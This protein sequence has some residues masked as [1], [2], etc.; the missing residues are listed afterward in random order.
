[1][2]ML[3]SFFT[4]DYS[5]EEKPVYKSLI[6]KI[7][8]V[9]DSADFYREPVVYLYRVIGVLN[10]LPFFA[11]AYFL[12]FGD[13]GFGS[14][15]RYMA[16]GII[17][18]LVFLIIF[19]LASIY[20]L[21]FWINRSNCLRAKVQNGSDIV[22]ILIVA[23]FVQTVAEWYGLLIAIFAPIV[24]I[25]MGV[26][27]QLFISGGTGYFYFLLGAIGMIVVSEIIAYVIISGGHFF[28]ETMRA[29]ATITNNVRD[30]G[31]IHRAATMAPE[32][33]NATVEEENSTDEE[34]E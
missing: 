14:F 29:I 27:G 26:L 28:A 6:E 4:D 19:A 12:F 7:T 34:N 3:S 25:Y 23:D 30:L 21:L 13:D 24:L 31:D 20:G 17:N 2:S 18:K 9:V 22:V 33:P 15:G 10:L 11:L 1:M 16:G 5:Y 8:G 32:E